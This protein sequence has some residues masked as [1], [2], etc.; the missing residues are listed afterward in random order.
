MSQS[1]N[2]Q[3]CGAMI[4]YD[5][6]WNPMRVE[7]R[8]GRIDRIGQRFDE[9]TILNYSY[10]DTVETDIYDRLDDR[11]N[12]FESV[13][14]EMQPVLSGVSD[15]IRA[16]TLE[17]DAES[18]SEAVEAADRE[19]SEQVEDQDQTDRVDVGESLDSVDTLLEE[20]VVDEAKLDAWA[21]F[22]HP[23]LVDVG[24]D[25][26]AYPEPFHVAGVEAILV[27]NETLSDAGV[28]FVPA[29]DIDTSAATDGSGFEFDGATYRLEWDALDEQTGQNGGTLAEAIAPADGTVAVTFDSECA[30]EFPSIQYLAPGNPLLDRLVRTLRSASDEPLRLPKVDAFRSESISVPLVCGWSRTTTLARVTPQGAVGDVDDISAI[31]R[32][33]DEFLGNQLE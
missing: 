13:V 28:T 2:L 27:G 21:S 8:I 24:D 22:R 9:I 18:S 30:D 32:W 1:L 31:Q 23:D 11:I 33:R 29:T 10:E 14:G 12:L 15:Q 7:Q 5:L 20:D 26:Y 4:N 25:E 16:A 17:T 3:E 6:P 19:F